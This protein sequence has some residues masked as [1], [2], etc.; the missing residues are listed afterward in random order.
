MLRFL[1]IFDIIIFY[2]FENGYFK[3]KF[4]QSFKAK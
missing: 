4:K 1:Y 2:Y 3:S